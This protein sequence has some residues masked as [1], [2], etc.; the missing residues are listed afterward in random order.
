MLLYIVLHWSCITNKDL[1]TFTFRCRKKI[2]HFRYTSNFTTNNKFNP[3]WRDLLPPWL[4]YVLNKKNAMYFDNCSEKDRKDCWDR[5]KRE[6]V[7]FPYTTASCIMCFMFC[8]AWNITIYQQKL[9]IS[10]DDIGKTISEKWF[11]E[12]DCTIPMFGQ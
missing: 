10:E 9:R 12:N 6:M 7:L 2:T 3:S 4:F 5:D 1:F 8:Y 11:W